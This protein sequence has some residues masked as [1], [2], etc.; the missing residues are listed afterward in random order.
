MPSGAPRIEYNWDLIKWARGN[1][2]HLLADDDN[3]HR[4]ISGLPYEAT[5]SDYSRHRIESHEILLDYLNVKLRDFA[6]LEEF[7]KARAALLSKVFG[8]MGKNCFIEQHIF[9]DYGCNIKVGDNFYAN[10]NLTMLDC[11]VIE[12]GD[13]VFFGPNVTI[14][15]AS[16]PLESKPRVEG[17]EFA[18][19][20]KIGNN[21]WIGSSAVVLPGVTIGDDAVVAAGA[22]VNKDVPAS[23]V[24]GGVPAKILKNIQN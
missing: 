13:N 18:F 6:T 4:M 12:I 1:L 20:V 8:S 22:V 17:V 24:V 3:Y 9:V 5:R 11:S 10:N 16:H 23:V 7:N 2:S 21:V 14:T 15:T 19:N